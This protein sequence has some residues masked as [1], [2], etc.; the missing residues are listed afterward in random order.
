[1]TTTTTTS[2]NPILYDV[3]TSY[4]HVLYIH[5]VTTSDNDT[6]TLDNIT[7]TTDHTRGTRSRR[8]RWE[9]GERSINKVI[10][11]TFD[12]GKLLVR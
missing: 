8:R 2:S 11:A 10:V 4:H 9:R 12:I 1:M 7:T 5:L 3:G 6:T